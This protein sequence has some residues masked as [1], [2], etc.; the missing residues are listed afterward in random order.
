M[1][2]LLTDFSDVIAVSGD[3]LGHTKV[4]KHKINLLEN[5]KPIYI[6]AYCIPQKR[7]E[8][9]NEAVDD[10]LNQGI[11]RPSSSPF[12]FPLLCVLKGDGS[13]RVVVDF[14]KLNESTIPDRYPVPA[15][16]DLIMSIGRNRYFTTL[17]LLNGFL[18]VPL[19]ESFMHMTAFSTDRGHFEYTRMPFGL[20]SSPITFSRLIN[21]VFEGLMGLD[22]LAYMDDLIIASNSLEEHFEKLRRVLQRLRDS[23]LKIK[24]SKCNFL[25]KEIKYLGH[26]ICKDGVQV[27]PNKIMAVKDFPTPTSK[28]AIMQFLGLS[29]FFS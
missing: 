24:L 28:K 8:A 26:A 11:I 18:Q 4:L 1:Y 17:D 5:V 7:R 6:P 23:N 21:T 12:N 20:M 27:N 13:W 2:D 15:M 9:V 19:E 25:K 22:L 3:S 29:V 10:M 16:E 14:R